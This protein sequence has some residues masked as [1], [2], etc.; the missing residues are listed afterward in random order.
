MLPHNIVNRHVIRSELDSSQCQTYII[1]HVIK[2]ETVLASVTNSAGCV[3]DVM[4]NAIIRSASFRYN[5]HSKSH[6]GVTKVL[7]NQ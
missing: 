3:H 2:G 7:I 4:N 6:S 5:R 1:L